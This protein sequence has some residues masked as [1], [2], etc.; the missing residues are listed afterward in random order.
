MQRRNKLMTM[1]GGQK[2]TKK[3]QLVWKGEKTKASKATNRT[4]TQ[5][6]GQLQTKSLINTTATKGKAKRATKHH[7]NTSEHTKKNRPNLSSKQHRLN[8]RQTQ[9]RSATRIVER[10]EIE[11]STRDQYRTKRW[12]TK[13][14]NQ[15][16]IVEKP[17]KCDAQTI[18]NKTTCSTW[19]G[20][21]KTNGN[22][23]VKPGCGVV[24]MAN[25]KC[26][27]PNTEQQP[28][29]HHKHRQSTES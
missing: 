27:R 11:R 13:H 3:T 22:V 24:V 17:L 21:I 26:H 4:K 1:F 5:T 10:T 7:S 23:K 20:E 28:K 9:A 16:W 15:Q 14:A 25:D 8:A 12:H 19:R 6:S 29:T 18:G 2:T